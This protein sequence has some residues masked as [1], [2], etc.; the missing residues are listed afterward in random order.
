MSTLFAVE[1]IDAA[2]EATRT[3]AGTVPVSPLPTCP[4]RLAPH[5]Y[6]LPVVDT[7]YEVA[8]PVARLR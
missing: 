8:D 5:A 7:A 2:P 1:E 4:A 6:T 3:G